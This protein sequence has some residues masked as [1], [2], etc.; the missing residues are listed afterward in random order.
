MT[1]G[2]RP[3]RPPWSEFRAAL[4][5]AGFHPSK[6][7]GQNFLL[8][9]NMARTI[10]DEAGVGPGER[11]LEIGPGCGFL[12]VHLAHAGAELCAI[13]V[14]PRLA[15]I[16]R[17]FLAPYPRATVVLADALAGK[18]ELGPEVVAW[19]DAAPGV[20]W[21]L[22]SNL[23][24]SI[25]GPVL[26]LL[27]ARD[28][29]PESFTVLVQREVGERLAA[30]PGAPEWGPLGLAV[31]LSHDVELGRVVPPGLFWPRPKVDSAIVHGRLRQ[32][33]ARGPVASGPVRRGTVALARV[34]FTRRRQ[35][36]RRV[37]ADTLDDREAAERHLA[38]LGL[39]PTRRAETL[40]VT[41]WLALA[42]T[43]EGRGDSGA[44]GGAL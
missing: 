41:E 5:A 29:P 1:G 32:G 12:S 9:E 39:D 38:A 17:Q 19:L 18:N 34:L 27:C 8:D 31:Q 40:D 44:L 21:R 2:P 26:A 25:S 43:V 11:V 3:P 22:V 35:G 20:P 16:A 33:G 36:L 15:P 4:E 14:D 10:A 42:A 37:L 6:R 13:E 28:E 24:Y 30:A 7:L 23:P